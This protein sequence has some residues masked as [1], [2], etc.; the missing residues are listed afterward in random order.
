MS[1]HIAILYWNVSYVTSNIL[2]VITDR[3][4]FPEALI[5][6]ACIAD[7]YVSDWLIAMTA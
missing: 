1:A 4:S 7:S 5:I 3:P 6:G 2:Y